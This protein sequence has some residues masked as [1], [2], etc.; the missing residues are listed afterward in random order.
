MLELIHSLNIR[1]EESIFKAGIFK[2]WYLVLAIALGIL[3]QVSVVA[4]PFLAEVFNVV[5]LNKMQWVYVC[6]ISI[7]PIVIME[8]QKWIRNLKYENSIYETVL[9]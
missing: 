9:R 6:S 1:S 8:A 5:P 7:L 4:I 2:N 3:L